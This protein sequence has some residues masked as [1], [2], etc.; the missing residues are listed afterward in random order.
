[1]LAPSAQSR[2]SGERS[3]RPHRANGDALTGS[4]TDDRFQHR[5]RD[6]ARLVYELRGRKTDAPPLVL[7]HS[8]GMD[9][10]FWNAVTPPLADDD[11]G[12]R[13]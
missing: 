9:R 11:R 12:A 10:T 5:L 13:L 8:L 3:E 7:I 2:L 1:M 6:G 4:L